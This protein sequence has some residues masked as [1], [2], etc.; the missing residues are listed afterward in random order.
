MLNREPHE[1]ALR[2]E[3][4]LRVTREVALPLTEAAE[5]EL[6]NVDDWILARID[7]EEILKLEYVSCP[8][9][10]HPP[11][12][13]GELEQSLWILGSR[14]QATVDSIRVYQDFYYSDRLET[15]GGIYADP[16]R[17]HG[18]QLREGQYL[19][20]G[21]NSPASSDGRR[22]GYVPESNLMGKALLVFWPAWPYKPY[23]QCKF[24]R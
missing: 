24:I 11:V 20:L 22:W 23:F 6:E 4:P 18:I 2:D 19:A 5:L 17:G 21:D 16:W 3:N 15:A 7:G 13:N 1:S 14:I 9:L 8:D 12:P 10:E